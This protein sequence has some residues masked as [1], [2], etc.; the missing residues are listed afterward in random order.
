MD[1]LN[2]GTIEPAMENGRP[3]DRG[4]DVHQATAL[5]ERLVR[6]LGRRWLHVQAVVER[7]EVLAD[8]LDDRQTV[9]AAAWLHDIGYSPQISHTGFHPL[10]GA[11]YLRDEGWPDRIVELVAHHSGARYEAAERGLEAELMAEFSFRDDGADDVLS[12]ADLTTGPAGE[13]F[14]YDERIAEILARYPVENPVHRAWLVAAPVLRDAV[15]RA[16]AGAGGSQSAT[17]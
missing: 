3:I 16:D 13:R 1:E 17:G 7:V 4:V 6:P 9:V 5:A 14:T 2:P 15:E 11:R 8:A 10:D 12:A